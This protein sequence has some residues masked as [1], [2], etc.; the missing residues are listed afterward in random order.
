MLR[1]R[2]Y[3]TSGDPVVLLHGGPGLPGYLAPVARALQDRWRVLEPFQRMRE[4]TPL[5]VALHVADLDEVIEEHCGTEPVALVGSS[6][7]GT[8]GL[9]FAARRPERVRRLVLVGCGPLDLAGRKAASRNLESRLPREVKRRLAALNV[10]LAG[11]RDED[12]RD[13]LFRDSCDLL[14]PHYSHDPLTLDLEIAHCDHRG[15]RESWDDMIR[16]Q[17]EGIVPA[18]FR[19]VRA[20]VVALHGD[21]DPHPPEVA[22]AALHR[23]LPDLRFRLLE[24]CGHFPWIERHARDEFFR[25]LEEALC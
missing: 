23:L 25:L 24:R 17:H 15:N 4:E 9:S 1:V 14:F 18:E 7:G 22:R 10:T 8:L 13:Q 20:P 6:W 2:R 5:T 21:T 19:D 16:L 11:E 12:R 3:G